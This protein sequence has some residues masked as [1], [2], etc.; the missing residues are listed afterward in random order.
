MLAVTNNINSTGRAARVFFLTFSPSNTDA[1]CLDLEAQAALILPQR[2]GNTRLHARGC[3]LPSGV[4]SLVECGRHPRLV[5]DARERQDVLPVAH[6]VRDGGRSRRRRGDT[7]GI[8]ILGVWRVS[9]GILCRSGLQQ[10][11][12]SLVIA[13]YSLGGSW[14]AR[15]HV[16]LVVHFRRRLVHFWEAF[17]ICAD[18]GRGDVEIDQCVSLCGARQEGSAFAPSRWQARGVIAVLLTGAR[19]ETNWPDDSSR[20]PVFLLSP[21]VGYA[22]EA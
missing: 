20:F 15:G 16:L 9:S 8:A 10:R 11:R 18:G 14:P 21:P 12:L 4:K 5:T 7:V 22:S 1:P 2:G 19:L 6:G 17:P 13:G 3:D